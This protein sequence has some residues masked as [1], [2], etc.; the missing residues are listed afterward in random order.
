MINLIE[1]ALNKFSKKIFNKLIEMPE[2][3]HLIQHFLQ[4]RDESEE[5][6]WEYEECLSVLDEK[7]KEVI[8]NINDPARAK[9]KPDYYIEEPF[10]RFP[11]KQ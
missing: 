8:S 9:A 6:I 4:H 10:F 2:I 11:S 3:S 7:S 5:N 1:N